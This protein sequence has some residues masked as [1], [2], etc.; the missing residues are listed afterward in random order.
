MTVISTVRVVRVAPSAKKN[1]WKT[2]PLNGKK[3]LKI[4][5]T[6]FPLC[7]KDGPESRFH[8]SLPHSFV[9]KSRHCYVPFVPFLLGVGAGVP[10]FSPPRASTPGNG[11]HTGEDLVTGKAAAEKEASYQKTT[12]VI[13]ARLLFL[14]LPFVPSLSSWPSPPP[15]LLFVGSENF[16]KGISSPSAL[17]C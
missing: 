9:M 4:W 3:Y 14:F 15:P 16:L 10:S 1:H 8:A 6:S 12:L 13:E 11:M 17:V 7:V 2:A 5:W